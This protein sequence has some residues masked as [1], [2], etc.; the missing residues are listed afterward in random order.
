MRM[1]RGLA[2]DSSIPVLRTLMQQERVERLADRP[3]LPG[4]ERGLDTALDAA[5]GVHGIRIFHADHVFGEFVVFDE[6][7]ACSLSLWGAA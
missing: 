3:R 1:N 4:I 2:P 5:E 7:H 6:L